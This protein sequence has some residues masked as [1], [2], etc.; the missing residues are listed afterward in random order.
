MRDGEVAPMPADEATATTAG[1]GVAVPHSPLPWVIE[2]P[3]HPACEDCDSE[4]AVVDGLVEQ[5]CITSPLSRPTERLVVATI[6]QQHSATEANARLI[7]AAPDL[8][9]ALK[10]LHERYI[11]LVVSGDCGNWDPSTEP[12]VQLAREAIA[13]AEGGH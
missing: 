2:R 13:I 1:V 7:A 10:R 11:T 4:D 3:W 6:H 12:E 9:A 8:L 5:I